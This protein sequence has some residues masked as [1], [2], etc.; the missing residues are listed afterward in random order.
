MY[1]HVQTDNTFM[2]N[3]GALQKVYS[4]CHVYQLVYI[5]AG[6]RLGGFVFYSEDAQQ[7]FA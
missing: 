1:V 4:A 2:V 7:V 3:C 5:Q 6:A